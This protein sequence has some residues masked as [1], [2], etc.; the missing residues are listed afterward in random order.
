MNADRGHKAPSTEVAAVLRGLLP[1]A[2][3]GLAQPGLSTG[4]AFLLACL[5]GSPAAELTSAV[6]QMLD[7]L[8]QA[9]PDS[10]PHEVRLLPFLDSTCRV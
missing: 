5:D 3:P 6:G 10:F 7:R 4:A 9:G 2:L 1:A 8:L